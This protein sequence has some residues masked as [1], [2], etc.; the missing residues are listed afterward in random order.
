MRDI[1][2]D[3]DRWRDE[4]RPIALATVVETWGSAPRAAGGKM[5]VSADGSISG[6]VSGGCVENAVVEAAQKTLA[7]RVPQLLHFGIS[8][9]TAWSVGL[10]CGGTIEVFVEPLGEDI[11]DPVREALL[12]ERPAAVATVIRGPD[13]LLGNKLALFADGSTAGTADDATLAAAR[14]A[15]AEGVSRRV[16]LGETELFVD[17]L[18]PSPAW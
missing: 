18:L 16:S 10:A 1:L 9:D 5:A 13:A 4:G 12:Q 11:F 17:V 8:D 6:S 2:S 3:I 14:T 15:L 7:S